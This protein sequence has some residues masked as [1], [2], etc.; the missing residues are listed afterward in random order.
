MI[1]PNFIDCNIIDCAIPSKIA[2]KY[3]YQINFGNSGYPAERLIH[4]INEFHS[5]NEKK[6]ELAISEV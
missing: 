3:C 6:A 1:N 2:I 5:M 4:V